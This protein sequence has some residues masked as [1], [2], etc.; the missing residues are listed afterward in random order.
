MFEVGF[1]NFHFVLEV[2]HIGEVEELVAPEAS[3]EVLLSH[4]FSLVQVFIIPV[5]AS[6]IVG[7]LQEKHHLVVDRCHLVSFALVDKALELPT[8]H[9]LVGDLI[10]F[11]ELVCI[12]VEKVQLQ[13]FGSLLLVGKSI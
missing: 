1:T 10:N 5:I 4:L 11:G 13:I 6:S 9:V 2:V 7:L 8:L 3:V 12:T